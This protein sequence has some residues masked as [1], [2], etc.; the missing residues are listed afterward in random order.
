MWGAQEEET[1]QEEQPQNAA[2]MLEP[3]KVLDKIDLKF[4][5]IYDNIIGNLS[6]YNLHSSKI[7]SLE[8]QDL[9]RNMSKKEK[10]D[11][12]SDTE[13]NKAD[14]EHLL[15]T[16]DSSLLSS[17]SDF[18]IPSERKARYDYY[19]EIPSVN[20]IAFRMLKVYIDNILIKNNQSKQ[21]LTVT[22]NQN[23]SSFLKTVE[24]D[25]G[26]QYKNFFKMG[27][28]FFDFQ[29]MLKDKIIPKMLKYGNVFVEIINLKNVQILSQQ[30]ELI[31][32]SITFKP[33]GATNKF[34]CIIEH[35]VPTDDS[36]AKLLEE[37]SLNYK[38]ADKKTAT[39]KFQDLLKRNTKRNNSALE[40]STYWNDIVDENSNFN[41][42][43][44]NKLNFD[45]LEDIHLKVINPHQVMIIEQDG[46]NYGYLIVEEESGSSETE[47]NLL[48]QFVEQGNGGKTS[49]EASKR[50]SIIDEMTKN[51]IT[52]MNNIIVKNNYESYEDIDL[53]SSLEN[54]L[55]VLLYNKMK[56]N[57]KL[58]FRF[59]NKNK[60]IN[61][62]TNVDKYDL[63]GTSIFDPIMQPVKMYTLALM[64]SIVSRLSRASVVRK[65]VVEAGSKKSHASMIA[66]LKKDIGN[67][68][69]SFESLSDIKNINNTL[70]DFRDIAT[71][72][73]NGQRFVDMEVV[74]MGD[75]ALPLNDMQELRNELI[76]STGVPS[77]YLN[78][79]DQADMRE[80]LV[81]LNIGFANTISGIQDNLDDGNNTLFNTLFNIVL[82]NN[83]MEDD[84]FIITNYYKLGLNPPVVLL[85][86]SAEASISSATNIIG[87]L[88]G[89]EFTIN[90]KDLLQQYI[91]QMDWDKLEDNGMA[92][93]K[94]LAKDNIMQ[95]GQEEQ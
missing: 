75:R 9:S 55:K 63:Y 77:V 48:K 1:G 81:N 86:Q 88:K 33:A 36:K 16:S 5:D 72:S 14:L 70:T 38:E 87:M 76:A 44:I 49:D 83:E 12:L 41:F 18:N 4:N 57:A 46:V 69:I 78:I 68:S 40:E 6:T 89:V 47:V 82:E 3:I 31:T 42:S 13:Q 80:T 24:E 17:L 53:T 59:L 35:E 93:I 95:Q 65:W 26:K 90:P 64:S 84:D 2:S 21:F 67:K 7:Q 25:I 74:P 11:I 28:V 45:C 39:E 71:I 94:K 34:E 20:Y 62:H 54:G 30:R 91:P 56:T 58:K 22:E 32:E 79:G 50:K 60:L 51:I 37:A 43:D 15:N 19:D 66:K 29:K 73:V 8:I 61:Y 23:N 52:S 27:L 92:F 85:L 10:D